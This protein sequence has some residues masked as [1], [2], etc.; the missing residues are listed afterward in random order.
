[1]AWVRLLR[2]EQRATRNSPHGFDVSVPGLGPSGGLAALGGPGCS[3]GILGIGLTPTPA[4]LAVGAILL[5]HR[6]ALGMEV[7]C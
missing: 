2:A 6:D 7:P 3:D 4:A 1:M 5:D